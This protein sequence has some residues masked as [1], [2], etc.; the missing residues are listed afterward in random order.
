MTLRVRRLSLTLVALLGLAISVVGLPPAQAV[1][2]GVPVIVAPLDGED[3]HVEEVP[4]LH[5]DF[6]DAPYGS[7]RFEVADSAAVVVLA[8]DVEHN[9]ATDPDAYVELPAL[10]VDQ[11]TVTVLDGA[12]AVVATSTFG[13][14][15]LGEP[16]VLCS[17]NLPAKVV[18]V[19]PFTSVYPTFDGCGGATVQWSISHPRT[20]QVARVGL[21]GGASLGRWLFRD[22]GPTGTYA[23]R[24]SKVQPFG[25][26]QNTTSTVVKFGSRI[27]LKA[28]TRTGTRVPL[29][30]VVSRYSPSADAFRRW[31]DRPIAI[32]YKDCA[33]C[34]WKFL[35]MDRTNSVGAFDITAISTKARYYRATVGETATAWGRTSSSVRR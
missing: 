15:D 27:S 34:P 5:L 22:A 28:G 23:V 21:D 6:D 8:A 14:F 31:A 19:A 9:E 3:Y 1:G 7:Y 35:A 32:S 10:G 24:P 18:A 17:V 26:N 2:T 29:S 30:G 25:I 13:T 4:D 16:P 12:D 33:A 11:Y 20:A